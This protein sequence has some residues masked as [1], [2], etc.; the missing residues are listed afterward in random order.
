MT[1]EQ[2]QA[3]LS[4]Y[5]AEK[6]SALQDVVDRAVR[7]ARVS[8]YCDQFE[9]TLQAV[10]PE[11]V[12]TTTDRYGSRIRRVFDTEGNT[13]RGETLA[14]LMN[15][16]RRNRGSLVYGPDGYYA[17]DD[18][19]RDGFGRTGYDIDG[20]DADGWTASTDRDGRFRTGYSSNSVSRLWEDD[21]LPEPD[22]AQR[23]TGWDRRTRYVYLDRNGNPRIGRAEDPEKDHPTVVLYNPTTWSP[24]GETPAPSVT[25]DEILDILDGVDDDDE[26]QDEDY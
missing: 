5:S 16:G 7:A 26:D 22:V 19:D 9:H 13:C 6:R 17:G 2:S 4:A 23:A 12:I 10:L 1:P 14:N 21:G 15:S 18:R 8:G 11:F 24:E 3:I 20:F 25:D